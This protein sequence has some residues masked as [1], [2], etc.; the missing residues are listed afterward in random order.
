MRHL[1]KN[2]KLSLKR[3]QRAAL[4]NSLVRAL[5]L[6]GRI[7]ISLARAK[8]IRPMAEKILTKAKQGDL[9]ARRLVLRYFSPG[10]TKKIIEEIA[11]SYKSRDGGYTKIIRLPNRKSDGAQMAIIELVKG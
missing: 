10:L 8:E 4:L 11:P 9:S 5:F 1:K 7:K 3:D 2:R 6:K